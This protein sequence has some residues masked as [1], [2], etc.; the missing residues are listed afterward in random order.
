MDGWT[1]SKTEQPNME[2][3]V[4][5]KILSMM[6]KEGDGGSISPQ[7]ARAAQELIRP[8]ILDPSILD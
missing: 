8:E 6:S 3:G 1:F 4:S 5:G 2:A 7:G